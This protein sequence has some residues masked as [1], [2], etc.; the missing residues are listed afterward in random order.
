MAPPRTRGS[1]SPGRLG[2]VGRGGS[3]AHAGIGPSSR[4]R[5]LGRRRL[6]RARGDRPAGLRA[7]AD[8]VAAPPRTR[9][10]ALH[11]ADPLWRCA[12]SPAHAGIGPIQGLRVS[13]PGGL[14]RARGDRPSS[15]R[16]TRKT[17]R[18]PPRTRGSAHRRQGGRDEA[19]GS[20]AHAGIGLQAAKP[21]GL[22]FRLPRARGDRPCRLRVFVAAPMA[23]PRTRGSARVNLGAASGSNGSPAHAGIGPLPPWWTDL[24]AWLPR[25]RGDRPPHPSLL[26][27]QNTAPPRTRGS[28]GLAGVRCRVGEGSPAHA[29][30]GRCARL[31]RSSRTGLPRARGDRPC[32]GSGCYTLTGAPP[33]TR[34]SASGTVLVIHS[35]LGSPAHA[36]IGPDRPGGGR[37]R[38]RLP[39]ARGDRPHEDPQRPVPALA[40]PR[41]R[42]SAVVDCGQVAGPHGSPAHAGIGRAYPAGSRSAWRLPR[43]RGDRPAI[44][45]MATGTDVAPPRT[46]GSAADQIAYG[47]EVPGSPAHAGIGP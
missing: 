5:G 43:A 11:K 26:P 35:R 32:P 22:A 27:S 12:G 13:D 44:T 42:G 37:A 4:P 17:R 18:A 33:R 31:R 16:R 21:L 28:A 36:G 8:T 25:A 20:P 7:L 29:G 39:R 19:T 41:T 38:S 2:H 14:P 15:R 6:P 10:S 47:G 30:I 24:G 34:G 9:G 40:P 1:A 3:P 46:R 23:P 45:P